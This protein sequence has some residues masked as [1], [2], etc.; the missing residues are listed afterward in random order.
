M[1][2]VEVRV[3]DLKTDAESSSAVQSGSFVADPDVDL[4]RA[5]RLADAVAAKIMAKSEAIGQ[6]EGKLTIEAFPKGH[7]Y[8]IKLKLTI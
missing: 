1:T 6:C 2:E 4:G 7:G 8:D 3:A 5:Q